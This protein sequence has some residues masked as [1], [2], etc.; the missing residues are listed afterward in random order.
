MSIEVPLTARPDLGFGPIRRNPLPFG[1][2]LS[3]EGFRTIFEVFHESVKQFPK[4][5]CV[6]WRPIDK[7]GVAGPYKWL[8]YEDTF[9]RALAFGSGLQALNLCPPNED[10]MRLLG[11]F[12]KNRLEWVVGEI[13][14]YSQS[15]IPVPF[16]DTLGADSVDYIVQQTGVKDIVCTSTEVGTLIDVVSAS[17]GSLL[18]VILMDGASL[19]SEEMQK[20][21]GSCSSVNLQVYSIDEVEKLGREN[22]APLLLPKGSDVA[23]FCYTSGTTGNPKGALIQHQGL[24]SCLQSIKRT[25]TD[26]EADDVHLSYLPLPHVFER[27]VMHSVFYGGGR[28]GFYQGDTLKI[29]EDIQALRPTIFPSVPRLLN[30]VYDKIIAGVDE[31]GGVK[32]WLFEKA[33][34][35][36]LAGLRSGSLKHRV[37]DTLVFGPMK[38]KIGFDRIRLMMTGSAPIADHVLNFLRAAFGVPVQEGYGQTESSLAIT[39]TALDDFTVGHVG[40]PVPTC[41]VRLVDVPEMGYLSTDSEHRGL[42]CFGRGEV[43]FRGGNCF[44]GY[45]KMPEKT[46]ETIDEQEWVHTGD[47]GLWTEDGKLKIIDRKKNIFKLSQGEYVAAEKIENVI[48]RSQMIAMCFIYGDSLQSVLVAVVVPDEEFMEANGMDPTSASTKDKIMQSLLEQCREAELKGFEI[49]KAIHVEPEVF[50][51]ENGLLTPTFKL[52]RQQAK[53]RYEKEIE[54]MYAKLNSTAK[55]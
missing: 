15:V 55:L 28:V 3:V 19:S 30:R 50:S 12:A 4:N 21:K 8:N 41:E 49:P 16:Y 45:Y 44:A 7:N 36:K 20:I 17:P 6:G 32:K 39:N 42:T 1:P 13:G 23:F 26:I 27:G 48:T 10:N 24:L 47:I 2:E 22:K 9:E 37:W 46:A 31:A 33:L 38:K 34:A 11:F 43:T 54:E 51:V 40:I 53:E 5:P 52:K 29:L 25:G 14:C 18:S 35:S